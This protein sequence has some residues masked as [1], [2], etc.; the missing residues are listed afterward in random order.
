MNFGHQTVMPGEALTAL[1]VRPGGRYMDLTAGGGGHTRRILEALD[2]TGEVLAI[3]QDPGAVSFLRQSLTPSHPNLIVR[4]ANF[5][6]VDAVMDELG[7]EM[8]DGML[9]DLGLSSYQLESSGRGF[10]FLKDEPLDMR[11]DPDA[12][13]PASWL[14][15][16]L[17][18]RELADL[19]YTL[20]EERASRRIARAI[21]Q[22]H[23]QGPIESSRRLAEVV[24]S[25]MGRGGRIHPATRTFMALRIAVNREL[26]SL[27]RLLDLAP[28]LLKPEGRLAA[29]SFHSLEDRLVKRAITPLNRA[30]KME[31][32]APVLAALFPRP[33]V[34]GPEELAQN[35]RARSAKLRAAFK[36][37]KEQNHAQSPGR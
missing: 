5:S 28:A 30:R 32:A 22:A 24:G 14:V 33:L 23:S 29:I 25:V 16:R 9:L 11:M 7:W 1:G 31:G 2:G 18:E 19:I 21:V 4:Q 15:N 13:R 17:G 10:S 34:A 37:V 6:Q 27:S 3:D 12:G 8:V 35:P 26:E 36:M 20:G